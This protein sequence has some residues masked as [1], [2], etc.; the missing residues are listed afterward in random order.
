MR[1]SIGH[2]AKNETAALHR[3]GIECI[4]QMRVALRRLNAT[5]AL[6]K[7]VIASPR[8]LRLKNELRWIESILGEA[9]DWDVFATKT[10]QRGDRSTAIDLAATNI[11]KAANARR[12]AAHRKAVHA[13]R[14]PRYRACSQALT[15]WVV[16]HQ[17]CE[18]LDSEVRPLLEAL[19]AEAGRPWLHRSAHKARKAGQRIKHLTGQQ[20]HR[21]R[22]ALK[23]LRYDSEALSSLY[24]H[25]RVKRFDRALRDLQAVLG[26]LNDLVVAR[27]LLAVVKSRARPDVD[28]GLRAALAER[29]ADLAPAW[30]A[31]R[32]IS[33][34]WV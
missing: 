22:I 10:L 2:L 33:P 4:H 31:F 7:D 32:D 19:L 11:V 26:D 21:L 8:T 29:L 6:F 16:D 23:R 15:T 20:R 18:R 13:V 28:A 17:W 27:R 1:S 30:H 25:R 5:L 9:R 3:G 12:R 24:A 14:S 34:F